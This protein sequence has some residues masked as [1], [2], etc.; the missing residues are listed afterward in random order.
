MYFFLLVIGVSPD[1]PLRKVNEAFLDR[2][3]KVMLQFLAETVALHSPL[4]LEM[5][6]SSG[7]SSAGIVFPFTVFPVSCALTCTIAT[8]A[9]VR[10]NGFELEAFSIPLVVGQSWETGICFRIGWTWWCTDVCFNWSSI[11]DSLFGCRSALGMYRLLLVRI[12]R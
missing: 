3:E 10:G 5:P 9:S 1:L 4:D 8:P 11:I 12:V 2:A 6:C 7:S